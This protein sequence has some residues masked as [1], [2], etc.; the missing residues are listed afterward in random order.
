MVNTR[1]SNAHLFRD[2]GKV[3]DPLDHDVRSVWLED[4]YLGN[5][6]QRGRGSGLCVRSVWLED[7]NLR[8]AQQRGRGSGFSEEW[9]QA[10]MVQQAE[11]FLAFLV[12][13]LRRIQC[14]RR[15]FNA[16][17]A[18]V[19]YNKANQLR[20]MVQKDSMVRI[21]DAMI[22]PTTAK[23]SGEA[24]TGRCETQGIAMGLQDE[25]A[26]NVDR[27]NIAS[28]RWKRTHGR[29][30]LIQLFSLSFQSLFVE[31]SAARPKVPPCAFS[32]CWLLLLVLLLRSRLETPPRQPSSFIIV[33][34]GAMPLSQKS[35]WR[36]GQNH[37]V[38]NG[39]TVTAYWRWPSVTSP[40]DR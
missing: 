36:Y 4:G 16:F 19:V 10:V 5:V 37:R 18:Q 8:N 39:T 28:V 25:F 29:L 35:L 9:G 6:Q 3:E 21:L 31:F 33:K 22:F 23:E 12:W 30:F 1:R 20:V 32:P 7:G 15:V 40:L 13:Y 34:D 11:P 38:V 24:R 2:C 17:H 27:Y 14:S 26:T